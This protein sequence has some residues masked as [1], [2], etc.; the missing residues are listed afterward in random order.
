MILSRRRNAWPA[1]RCVDPVKSNLTV[2]RYKM[3]MKKWRWP[4]FSE[5]DS[6]VKWFKDSN[7]HINKLYE[8]L[9]ER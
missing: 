9:I 3:S 7:R 1:R 8:D 6:K 2:S 5:R 4:M